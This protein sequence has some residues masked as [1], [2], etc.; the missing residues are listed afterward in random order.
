[1]KHK[2][3][4]LAEPN[5]VF[6]DKRGMGTVTSTHPVLG[7][8]SNRPYDYPLTLKGLAPSLRI[9]IV[10]PRSET[11]ILRTYLQNANQS[12]RPAPSETDYLIDY[13]GFQQAYGL[14]IEIPEPGSPGW[15]VCAEPAELSGRGAVSTAQRIT[16]ALEALYSSYAPHVVLIF[17]P[18]R[19][20]QVRGYRNDEERFDVH[21]FVKAYAVQRGVAT[22]FLV[23]ETLSDAQQCRV[24]WWLSLALYVKGMRTP[25]VL[26]R[27]D[28]ETAFIGLGFSID[29]Y[30]EKGG[31]VVLGCSHIYSSR[32]EG[33]QYRLSKVENPIIRGKNPFMS[34][35]DARRTGEN[36]RQIF[37][38]GRSKLPRR[39]VL[40]KRTPFLKD[41]REGLLDGLGGV[42]EID[43]LEIQE[44]VAL[45]YVASMV[46]HDGSFDE[47]NYPVRRGTCRE[48]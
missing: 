31:H 10:C 39:V 5:L 2:G 40:H 30:A 28:D 48:A 12:H 4:E 1:M 3:Q 8:V 16:G 44:D 29:R 19:W 11:S 47:D 17:F 38:E 21:D 25:W 41:E 27:L 26:D 36:I 46:R 14:P 13:P 24:W 6:Y 20:D 15:V 37:F 18:R 45:R 32:G 35:D 33:L 22:Q 23:E 42:S 34:R 9:G 43:M 7:M